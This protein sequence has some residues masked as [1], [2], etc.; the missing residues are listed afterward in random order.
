MAIPKFTK[1]GRAAKPSARV[2]GPV[3][4]FV[5]DVD[6]AVTNLPIQ[7]AVAPVNQ[8]SSSIPEAVDLFLDGRGERLRGEYAAYPN[9]T[10]VIGNRAIRGVKVPGQEWIVEAMSRRGHMI[11]A[12]NGIDWDKRPR[13]LSELGIQ[14]DFSGKETTQPFGLGAF[15]AP[16]GGGKTVGM[17]TL[18]AQHMARGGKVD[19]VN[20]GEPVPESSTDLADIL[21]S[22]AN[23]VIKGEAGSLLI[24]DSFKGPLFTTPGTA[25]KGGIARAFFQ[26]LSDLSSVLA[27]YKIVGLGAINFQSEEIPVIKEITEALIG[28]T[29]GLF[30]VVGSTGSTISYRHYRRNYING[31]RGNSVYEM[32]KPTLVVLEDDGLAKLSNVA[33]EL[34]KAFIT[35][36]DLNDAD[37]AVKGITRSFFNIKR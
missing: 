5:T 16:S 23:A 21:I 27:R 3:D 11:T 12:V 32:V 30:E 26:D 18:S 31:D 34:E 10:L 25:G 24:F 22:I 28:N 35:A 19:Y 36:P 2:K 6:A 14:F 7:E 4:E 17:K 20:V 15:I 37:I 8:A 1:T 9:M 33:A 29:V 13:R